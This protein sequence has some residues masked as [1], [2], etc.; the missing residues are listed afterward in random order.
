MV[1]EPF[2]CLN[3]SPSTTFKGFWKGEVG[4]MMHRDVLI[5]VDSCVPSSVDVG[6]L[7]RGQVHC[8][9]LGLIA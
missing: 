6:T 1:D 5:L 2:V 8:L 9:F 3:P 7:V 4:I